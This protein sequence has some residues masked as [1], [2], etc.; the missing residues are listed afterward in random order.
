MQHPKLAQGQFLI[1]NHYFCSK[2]CIFILKVNA[3]IAYQ[4]D[5]RPDQFDVKS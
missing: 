3:S 2:T 5:F 1:I 4:F